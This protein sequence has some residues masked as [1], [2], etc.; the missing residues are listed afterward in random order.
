MI[1]AKRKIQPLIIGS[2]IGIFLMLF[3]QD[4]AVA[5]QISQTPTPAPQ[6]KSLEEMEI[7]YLEQVLAL[8]NLDRNF[9]NGFEEKLSMAQ[10][11]LND[12]SLSNSNWSIRTEGILPPPSSYEEKIF[13]EGIFEGGEGLISS[14]EAF[15][16]NRWQGVDEYGFIQVFAGFLAKNPNQGVIYVVNTSVDRMDTKI[17]AF[18][19]NEEDGGLTVIEVNESVLLLKSENMLFCFDVL[20]NQFVCAVN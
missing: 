1:S 5:F 3:H 2:L 6:A 12:R 17:N 8:D 4:I 10:S 7:Q 13:P 18:Y 9:R 15:I 20:K 14:S 11:I 19:P 16:N